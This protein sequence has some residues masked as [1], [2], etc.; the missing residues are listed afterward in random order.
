MAMTCDAVVVG[1]GVIGSAIAF[2]LASRGLHVV[3]VDKG[4]AAGEGS[5]SAS[6]A[7]VRFNYSTRDGVA[8]AWESMHCWSHWDEH[9]A[10]TGLGELAALRRTGSIM[11]DVPVAPREPTIALYND[12]GVPYQ[13]WDSDTLTA[14]I[15]S[16][17]AGRHWPPKRV[18]DENFGID[19]VGSVGAVYTP[20]GGFID[21]PVLATQNLA[22]AGAHRG[23]DFLL[24][25][26]VVEVIRAAGRVQGV[27]TSSGER[28]AAGILVN[29][30]GPWSSSLNELAGV[31]GDF[32]VAIRPLRVEV[33]QVPAP[34]GYNHGAMLGPAISDLDLGIYM[35]P[36]AGD[37]LLI[38]GTEPA[39]DPLD[40]LDDP[41]V[42]NQGRGLIHFEAQVLRAARR[43]PGLRVPLSPAGV[44]GVY[45]V[46]SDWTPI[47]DRTEL[48]GFYV[49]MG[50]SGNQF[51]NAPVVGRMM[52]ALIEN[53]ESGLD[54]DATPLAYRCE[55]TDHMINLGTFSRKRTINLSSTNTVLG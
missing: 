35:R 9:L 40:W 50:T 13:L 54:H 12:L 20:D 36:A 48:P 6:S 14:R 33:H 29:A 25:Q 17:D 22:R 18:G 41:D 7:I 51:K 24:R 3:A 10:T 39:C 53:V 5:T 46:A 47:Y 55:H 2:E 32:A 42:P 21:D 27:R 31:G 30:A 44:V 15:P 26:Q 49:A 43:L 19:P 1:A 28:I 37:L 45:D 8:A 52:A 34:P 11:L 23:V 16:L 4:P 38:G